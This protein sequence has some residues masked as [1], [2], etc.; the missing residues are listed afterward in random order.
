MSAAGLWQVN[1]S[2]IPWPVVYRSKT[3]EHLHPVRG[4]LRRL[5]RRSH[6]LLLLL[7][8]L[9]GACLNP[10]TDDLP[11]PPDDD[12]EQPNMPPTGAVGGV[13]SGGGAGSND[14]LNPG[15]A[16][17]GGAAGAGGEGA[18]G[19]LVSDG[20]AGDPPDAGPAAAD[21]AAEESDAG[22]D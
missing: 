21:A 2:I 22:T 3:P 19:S 7:G 16:G 15:G 20:D 13:G 8:L 17:S 11:E 1:C 6:G 12:G 4:L 18:G 5:R 14:G 9:A 10:K